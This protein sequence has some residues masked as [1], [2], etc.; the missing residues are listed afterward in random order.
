MIKVYALLLALLV[1]T[2]ATSLST[3]SETIHSN[4]MIDDYRM[5]IQ[6][7]ALA[8]D[9]FTFRINFPTPAIGSPYPSDLFARIYEGT[10]NNLISPQPA[11]MIGTTTFPGLHPMPAAGANLDLSWVL[12]TNSDPTGTYWF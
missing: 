9:S 10:W 2:P 11:G 12:A 3:N 8:S 1:I 6:L 4:P 7:D 5:R